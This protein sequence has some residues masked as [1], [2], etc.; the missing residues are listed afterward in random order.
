MNASFDDKCFGIWFQ[1]FDKVWENGWER[2]NFETE[3][4][5]GFDWKD[6]EVNF[7]SCDIVWGKD[8]YWGGGKCW[9][10]KVC[11]VDRSDA[12]STDCIRSRDFDSS[13]YHGADCDESRKAH[14][15]MGCDLYKSE[16]S[17]K[18][19]DAEAWDKATF[20]EVWEKAIG[21]KAFDIATGAEAIDKATGAGV[22]DEA[23]GSDV[24]GKN[25]G[26]TARDKAIGAAD[27]AKVTGAEVVDT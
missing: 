27:C 2:S 14:W 13:I 6:R 15:G 12:C 22:E 16:D 26:V 19:I 3:L 5:F 1:R 7:G 17:D 9:R 4:G 23:P 24:G 18:V 8:R 20:A 11:G 10:G 25:A 21:A